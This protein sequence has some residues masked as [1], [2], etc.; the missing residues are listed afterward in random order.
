MYLVSQ[1]LSAVGISEDNAHGGKIV[2]TMTSWPRV[3]VGKADFH[4]YSQCH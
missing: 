3:G 4:C 1:A 2:Q